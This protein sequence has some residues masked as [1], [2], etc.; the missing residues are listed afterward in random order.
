[1]KSLFYTL[2][3]LYFSGVVFVRGED[4]NDAIVVEDDSE[5]DAS[6]KVQTRLFTGNQ[7]LD[8]GLAGLALGVGG[9]LV[10][11]HLLNEN[12]KKQQQKL[13][14]RRYKRDTDE[15]S[16]RFLNFGGGSNNGHHQNGSI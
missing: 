6:G 3:F 5:S 1:M 15:P 4:D 11:G 2:I 10:V 9:A 16:L 13:N 7:E 14:C 12:G 8:A